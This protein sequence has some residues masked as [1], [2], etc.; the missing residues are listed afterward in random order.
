MATPTLPP[1]FSEFL[2]LLNDRGIEYLVIGGWAVSH[3]GYVRSTA[4]MDV[5]IAV[6]PETAAKMA[7]ALREF[8]FDQPDLTESLFLTKDKLLRLGVP[9]FR[10]EIHTGISGVE[11]DE[12]YRRRVIA[13][14]DGVEVSLISLDDLKANKRASGRGK[15]LVDLEHLP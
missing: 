5:W 10:L 12:A 6:D 8:G 13:S 1:D 9:P 2:K 3:Y 14:K 4:D 11:F 15:D 7:A